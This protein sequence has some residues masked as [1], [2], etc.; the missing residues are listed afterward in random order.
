M[1]RFIEIINRDIP[2]GV[3]SFVI[4]VFL[5]WH[6]GTEF[7]YQDRQWVGLLVNK[8]CEQAELKYRYYDG[9]YSRA[10]NQINP[11][12]PCVGCW[13]AT[14]KMLEARKRALAL[15]KQAKEVQNERAQG[16]YKTHK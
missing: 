10:Y 8:F 9:R 5:T 6:I 15:E 3:W 7:P 13:I 12:K 1:K 14:H 16:I 11:P 4:A 2:G